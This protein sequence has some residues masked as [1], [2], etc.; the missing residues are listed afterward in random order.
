MI[1]PINTFIKTLIKKVQ[2]GDIINFRGDFP[3]FANLVRLI[4]RSPEGHSSIITDIS[5]DEIIITEV[6]TKVRATKLSDAVK[7]NKLFNI[8][9]VKEWTKEEREI[10]AQQAR[11]LSNTPY[12]WFEILG[13]YQGLITNVSTPNKYLKFDENNN[14]K[15]IYCSQAIVWSYFKAAKKLKK[16]PINWRKN[17]HWSM[18]D[19]GSIGYFSERVDC[20]FEGIKSKI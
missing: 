1:T 5:E 17:Y 10:A 4:T 3:F 2:L 8:Y 15:S 14:L 16:D 19:P 7:K 6:L 12:A 9:R 11:L 13:Y 20:I 18:L